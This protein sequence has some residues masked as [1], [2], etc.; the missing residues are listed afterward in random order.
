MAEKHEEG[1]T[2]AID[3]G[4]LLT[5]SPAGILMQALEL[6]MMTLANEQRTL[7]L[8]RQTVAAQQR[9]AEAELRA[10]QAEQHLRQ[11]LDETQP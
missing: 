11:Y 6:Q 9:A 5:Q 2:P 3:E 7:E 1:E 10:K 4:A 8:R